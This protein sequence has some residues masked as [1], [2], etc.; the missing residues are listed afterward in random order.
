MS[1]PNTN[2]PGIPRRIPRRAHALEAVL[3]A[4]MI[5]LLL[6]IG[7][8]PIVPRLLLILAAL[9]VFCVVGFRVQIRSWG[10]LLAPALTPARISLSV[11]I[12]VLALLVPIFP[13]EASLLWRVATAVVLPA[14]F[15][16]LSRWDDARTVQL[17]RM[18]RSAQHATLPK[19]P[20]RV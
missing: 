19:A 12:G 11:F 20:S 1:A 7:P 18:R 8:V 14:A 2:R 5:A 16:A 13:V 4:A 6:E 10:T 9:V 17:L 3:I 15:F